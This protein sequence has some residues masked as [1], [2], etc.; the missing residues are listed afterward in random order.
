MV[1]PREFDEAHVVEQAMTVFWQKGY[2]GTSVQDLVEATGLQRGSLYGAFGDKHSLFLVALR[3]YIDF[4][5]A[6]FDAMLA[7]ADNPVDAIREFVR[8]GGNDC[9]HPITGAHGCMLGNT[10]NELAAHDPQARKMA[11]DGAG[12]MQRRIADALRSAQASGR[13]DVERDPDAV[14]TFIQCGLQ[15]LILLA[16]ARPGDDVIQGVVGEILRTLD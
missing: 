11:A 2:E 9:A 15:G 13:F 14:A 8:Q 3:T 6:R 1:R 10:I 16:K 5:L 4:T 7:E 12:R